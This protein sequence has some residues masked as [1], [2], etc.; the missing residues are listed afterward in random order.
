MPVQSTKKA[1]IYFPDGAKVSVKASGESVFTD[2]GAISTS[3]SNSFTW[4]ENQVQTANAGDLDKQIS[5][6]KMEGGFTLINLEPGSVSRLSGGVLLETITAGTPF[7]DAPDETISSGSWADKT[8]IALAPTTLAGASVRA[9]ALA[10]TSVTGSSDGALTADDDYTLFPDSASPSG[11]SI[12]VN[13][14]GTNVTTI[15]QDLVI[16]YASI[17]PKASTKISGGSSTFIMQGMA[18]QIVHTDDNGLTRTLDLYSVD[19]NSGGFQ[20]NFKGANEDGTEEMP[21]TFTAKLDTS[22]TNKDQLFAWTTEDG[23]Q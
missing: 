21:L 4:T 20:F 11:Y 18:I 16:S 22:R 7:V 2:V 19:M 12:S 6:M 14:A 1:N 10:L 8:P 23:A 5:A 13:L 15:V 17:T 9:T 3:V